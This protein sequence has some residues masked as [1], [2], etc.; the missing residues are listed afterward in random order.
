MSDTTRPADRCDC[1]VLAATKGFDI[2][3]LASP[4]LGVRVGA[5]DVHLQFLR[6]RNTV[7]RGP[8]LV[9]EDGMPLPCIMPRRFWH[10]LSRARQKAV[11]PVFVVGHGEEASR[12]VE[13]EGGLN[14]A[15]ALLKGEV[16]PGKTDGAYFQTQ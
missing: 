7:C 4:G 9:F 1:A 13:I 3:R 10:R 15:L 6:A 14:L 16:V 2:E 11:L 12:R 5:R 8:L